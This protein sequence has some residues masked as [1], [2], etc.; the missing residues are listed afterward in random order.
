M[1]KY[2]LQARAAAASG[3]SYEQSEMILQHKD[4]LMEV[5]GGHDGFVELSRLFYHSVFD[6]HSP[7][8][9][10]QHQQQKQHS[11]TNYDWFLN[12][13]ASSTQD[14]AIDNQATF[15][16][17]VFGG[18]ALYSQRKQLAPHKPLRLVGRH[19]NYNIGHQAADLWIRHM[20]YALQHHSAFC[21]KQKT[22][23]TTTTTT[24]TS[25]SGTNTTTTAT[26]TSIK[27]PSGDMFVV[28]LQQKDPM[29]LQ[30][31]LLDYFQYTAHYIVVASDYMRSDQV[32]NGRHTTSL[33]NAHAL[34]YK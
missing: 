21:T 3:V 29:T 12:I 10:D 24:T 6:R 27:I 22:S 32:R 17:Q 28:L 25:T 15:L 34:L 26:D 19:A 20:E 23:A 11:T 30:K 5:I 13:F 4:S 14:E 9:H 8:Y 33:L 16:T 31:A 7:V 2:E 18:P 1:S